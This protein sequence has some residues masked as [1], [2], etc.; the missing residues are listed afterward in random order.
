MV[1][2][3]ISLAAD[4]QRDLPVPAYV[5][6]LG[7]FALFCVLMMGLLMFGKGRPHT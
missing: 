1:L 4:R 5:V 6:G 3:L 7:S 2:S